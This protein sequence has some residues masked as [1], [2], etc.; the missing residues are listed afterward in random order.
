M[1]EGQY[2]LQQIQYKDSLELAAQQVESKIAPLFMQNTYKGKAVS[3]VDR[4]DQFEME[5]V[6]SRYQPIG[7]GETN[8]Q[9]RWNFPKYFSKRIVLDSIDML[10]T[11][12][13]PQS[14]YVEGMQAAR[15]RKKDTLAVDA[16]FGDA[17]VGVAGD[18]NVTWASEGSAQI[19][20]QT[21]GSGATDSGFNFAKLRA[22]IKIMRQNEIPDSEQVYVALTANQI[23]KL[24]DEALVVSSEHNKEALNA[25]SDG[26]VTRLLGAYF[27]LSER[28]A[29]DGS[30]FTRVP[31]WTKKAMDWGMWDAPYLDIAQDKT[32]EGHPIAIYMKEACNAARIDPMRLVEIKCA[33]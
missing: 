3:P 27:V 6:S 28:L 10:E 8:F 24:Y 22:A 20:L 26:K 31:V 15:A 30:G 12:K 33:V 5:D 23:D 11:L 1:A 4:L 9:R 25:I 17:K 19:V 14:I 7:R 21:V 2:Q 32:L 18:E 29:V 16:F 13:N